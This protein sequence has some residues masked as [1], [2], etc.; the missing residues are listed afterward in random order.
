[1]TKNSDA[2]RAKLEAEDLRRQVD[3][4]EALA[5]LRVSIDLESDPPPKAIRFPPPSIG[6]N[7]LP[8][9]TTRPSLRVQVNKPAGRVGA[10]LALIVGLGAAAKAVADALK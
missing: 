2:I 7:S 6:S 10:V 9:P 8:P 3:T 5:R 1:M 4:V